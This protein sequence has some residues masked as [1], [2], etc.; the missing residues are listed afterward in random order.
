MPSGYRRGLQTNPV[1]ILC[2]SPLVHR[3]ETFCSPRA[4]PQWTLRA[5]ER[6]THSGTRAECVGRSGGLLRYGAQP[7]EMQKVRALAVLFNHLSWFWPRHG[8]NKPNLQ[9]DLADSF[10]LIL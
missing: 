3:A 8:C 7:R 9:S 4:R 6:P 10:T 2:A 5:P 1:N